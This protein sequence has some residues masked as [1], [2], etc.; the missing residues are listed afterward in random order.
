MPGQCTN[1]ANE[2]E[3]LIAKIPPLDIP[4]L[5]REIL[6]REINGC[7]AELGSARTQMLLASLF[8]PQPRAK[9]S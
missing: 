6:K 2:V 9:H 4:I 3:H 7:E 1:L 5:I 8:P